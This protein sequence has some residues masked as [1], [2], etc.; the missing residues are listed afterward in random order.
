MV[1][2]LITGETGRNMVKIET[3]A[4]FL[5]G[6]TQFDAHRLRDMIGNDDLQNIAD[7]MGVNIEDKR[8]FER[9]AIEWD[10]MCDAVKDAEKLKAEN[11]TLTDQVRSLSGVAHAVG[12]I[13]AT[14]TLRS[15][16]VFDYLEPKADMIDID[17]IAWG[18]A[19]CG[20]YA[21]Q[22]PGSLVFSVAQHSCMIHDKAPPEHKFSGLMHD[23]PEYVVLDVPKPLKMIIGPGYTAVEDRVWGVI[24]ACF[25]LPIKLPLIIKQLDWRMLNTEKKFLT[26]D[27]RHDWNGLN[28]YP[29]FE[30]VSAA[31][32]YPWTAEHAANEF[33][34]RFRM[35]R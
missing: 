29:P 13:G 15:G 4:N 31:D 12:V 2:M 6:M 19:K 34:R 25:D 10:Q 26:I 22:L 28:D 3:V 20:R 17:D 27:R 9:D 24:A 5:R 7:L 18:L 8:E 32:L 16:K 14:I 23:S 21:N 35:H 30:D 33:L 11:R 1:F